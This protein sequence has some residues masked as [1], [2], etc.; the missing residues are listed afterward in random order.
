MPI[1]TI[2]INCHVLYFLKISSLSTSQ[3][4]R[5]QAIMPINEPKIGVKLKTGALTTII[6]QHSKMQKTLIPYRITRR[7]IFSS[8]TNR[9]STLTTIPIQA[10]RK[11]RNIAKY[12]VTTAN[13]FKIKLSTLISAP[14]ICCAANARAEIL[15]VYA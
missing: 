14:S 12:A 4:G 15:A 6:P 10:S 11:L 8:G 7:L 13:I 5:K 9:F 1:A 3:V 2:G